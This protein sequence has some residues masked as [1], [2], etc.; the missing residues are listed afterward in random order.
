MTLAVPKKRLHLP[1]NRMTKLA[2]YHYRE[3]RKSWGKQLRGLGFTKPPNQW[4]Q[5]CP[6]RC[7]VKRKATWSIASCQVCL[8]VKASHWWQW[9]SNKR[10]MQEC[11]TVCCTTNTV[12]VQA[13]LLQWRPRWRN[14][15]DLSCVLHEWHTVVWTCPHVVKFQ[16]QGGC[17][18][19]NSFISCLVFMWSTC[20]V[21]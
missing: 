7:Q 12:Q 10:S 5:G 19:V 4:E 16:E 1:T 8:R 9:W 11:I 21:V 3:E 15:K 20:V 17:V 14:Q 18:C 6:S 2:K 13:I